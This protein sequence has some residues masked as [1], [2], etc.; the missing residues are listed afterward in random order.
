MQESRR[1]FAKKAAI[2]AAGTVAVSSTV[3]AT[4]TKGTPD[5]GNGVNVGKSNKKEILYKKTAKW[6]E[7]YKQAL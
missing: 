5:V 3:L 2:I 6:E 7:F 4:S 1:A